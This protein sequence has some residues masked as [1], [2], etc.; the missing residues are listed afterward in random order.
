M[1]ESAKRKRDATENKRDAP[2]L[3]AHASD[4][5]C[6]A[7]NEANND[8][9]SNFCLENLDSIQP[10]EKRQTDESDG[11]DPHE[12]PILQHTHKKI[13]LSLQAPTIKLAVEQ[14]W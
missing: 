6:G 1:D 5:K 8:L 2:F 3:P 9:N 11:H 7:T 14:D 4:P 13:Q 10:Q 12:V